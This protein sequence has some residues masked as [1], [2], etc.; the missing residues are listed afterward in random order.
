MKSKS[1]DQTQDSNLSVTDPWENG[2]GVC[3]SVGSVETAPTQCYKGEH[4]KDRAPVVTPHKIKSP[5]RS[6]LIE[7]TA[8]S[9]RGLK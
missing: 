6:Q 5:K 3:L 2:P 8:F 1:H 4:I 9:S 7:Q